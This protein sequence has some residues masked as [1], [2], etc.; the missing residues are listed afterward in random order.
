M[1]DTNEAK[2]VEARII[3][4][5][6]VLQTENPKIAVVRIQ[7]SKSEAHY[8]LTKDALIDMANLFLKNAERFQA[9]DEA[10][11]AQTH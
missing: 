1:S 2:N 5:V 6:Q 7:T 4:Q 8:C 3:R 10:V 11:P 9:D